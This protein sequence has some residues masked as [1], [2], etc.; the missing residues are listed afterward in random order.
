LV[1]LGPAALAFF[2]IFPTTER[3]NKKNS[4][5]ERDYMVLYA[6]ALPFL[7]AD[8]D[9]SPQ[10]HAPHTI[11]TGSQQHARFLFLFVTQ[12][13]TNQRWLFFIFLSFLFLS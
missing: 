5:R 12:T 4:H 11:Y 13:D 1:F 6:S 8:G 10:Q 9:A 2:L 7:V 3:K